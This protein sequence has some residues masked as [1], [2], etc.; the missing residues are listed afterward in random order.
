MANLWY[1]HFDSTAEDRRKLLAEDW[2]RYIRGFITDGIRNGGTCLKASPG[3]GMFVNISPGIATVQGYFMEITPDG[4][5][6]DYQLLVPAAHPTLSRIDRVV[7]RLDRTISGRKVTPEILLGTASGSPSA[8]ALT[9]TQNI[10]ELSLAQVKVSG[11]AASVSSI[12]I[13]DERFNSGLCGLM[14]SVLGLDPS[15]WQTQFDA[16]LTG[17]KSENTSFLADRLAGFNSQLSAQ[18]SA[19]DGWL[20][21]T[22]NTYAAWFSLVKGSLPTYAA[23]NFDNPM[24]YPGTTTKI[25]GLNTNTITETKRNSYDDS[26]VAERVTQL[27]VSGFL[28]VETTSVYDGGALFVKRVVKTA[29]DA[30]YTETTEDVII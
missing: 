13:T 7:L 3:G 23:F 14:N 26:L 19:F 5:G 28:S 4:N 22:K 30:D 15:A 1:S 24:A 10:W 6:T 9:R 12:D 11:G 29:D 21:P 8:P 17:I 16:F 2:A 20:N 25:T 18:Q 27:N